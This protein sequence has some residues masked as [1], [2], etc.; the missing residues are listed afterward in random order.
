MHAQP[1]M[2]GY[3]GAHPVQPVMMQGG[4]GFKKGKFKGGKGFKKGKFKK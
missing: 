1:M 3:P 4:K 2:G